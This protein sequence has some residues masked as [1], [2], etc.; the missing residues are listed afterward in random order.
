MV[1]RP[2]VSSRTPLVILGLG[3]GTCVI[4]GLMM[5]H[6]LRVSQDRSQPPVVQELA[7]VF[8]SRLDGAPH[9]RVV[10]R[11]D[12][13]VA[14]LTVVPV[15]GSGSDQFLLDMGEFVWRNIDASAINA[16]EIVCKDELGDGQRV[17]S[18]PRPYLP[19][20]GA[21][22]RATAGSSKP[23]GGKPAPPTKPAPPAGLRSR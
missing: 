10:Q 13:I 21:A 16:V 18:V 9:L 1:E 6:L 22:E 19:W 4:L 8:G 2:R 3:V 17:K 15:L 12:S 14:V 7:R 23:A 11:G 20:S 5:Q